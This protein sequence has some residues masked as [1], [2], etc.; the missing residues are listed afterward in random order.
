MYKNKIGR[1]QILYKVQK[2]YPDN[3]IIENTIKGVRSGKTKILEH[4]TEYEE[5][6][7]LMQQFNK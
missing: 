2:K 7:F 6:T 4:E 1:S 5:Y 3:G